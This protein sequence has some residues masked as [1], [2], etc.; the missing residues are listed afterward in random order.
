MHGQVGLRTTSNEKSWRREKDKLQ[1]PLIDSRN[2]PMIQKN[3]LKN[4]RKIYC[5]IKEQ[6]IEKYK[7]NSLKNIGQVH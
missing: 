7:K 3:F 4:M 6:F 5:K 2:S 1:I